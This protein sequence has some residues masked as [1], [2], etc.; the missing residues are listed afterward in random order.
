MHTEM[1]LPHI[2]LFCIFQKKYQICKYNCISSYV[3]PLFSDKRHFYSRKGY[4]PNHAFVPKR[5]YMA[6]RFAMG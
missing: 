5:V 1:D 4:A 6:I 3:A 2:L